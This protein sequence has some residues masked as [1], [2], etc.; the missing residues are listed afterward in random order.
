M[1][2]EL[3]RSKR[4]I[5]A[6]L[7]ILC[8][9][10]KPAPAKKPVVRVAVPQVHATVLTIET[11]IK[12]ANKK[13]V[14]SLTIANNRARG[15][16]ELD[17]WRLIDLKSNSVS[18]VDSIAHTVHTEPVDALIQKRRAAMAAE[19]PGYIPRAEVAASGGKI[20]IRAGGYIREL[21]IAQ[22]R[23][24]PP[25]L[26]SMMVAS[27]PLS[28]PYAPMMKTADE[29]LLAVRGFP[30]TDH[31]ELALDGKK[32]VIDRNVVKVEQKNIDASWLEVPKGFSASLPSA[33]SPP[34]GQSTP[35][36][37]W[38]FFWRGRTSP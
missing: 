19:L 37:E 36:K 17:Q 18:Y 22:N 29:A 24:V 6:L 15:G 9:T 2:Q 25:Q 5:A 1:G 21:T 30:M 31:A 35:A 11:T 26:F 33:S 10:C 28:S 8:A 12:P 27:D 34:P 20:T 32:M 4:V 23:S 7:F 13:F 38:R 14:H 16:D 3:V